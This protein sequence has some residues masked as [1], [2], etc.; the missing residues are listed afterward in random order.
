VIVTGKLTQM[1]TI[2]GP[3]LRILSTVRT[4]FMNELIMKGVLTAVNTIIPIDAMTGG[5]G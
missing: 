2:A 5:G 1:V 4:N 3:F